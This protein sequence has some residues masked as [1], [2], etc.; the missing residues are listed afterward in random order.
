MAIDPVSAGFAI[1]R[2]LRPWYRLKLARNRRRARL[3]KPLLPMSEDD[4]QIFPN[5]T[6]TYTGS[7]GAILT[8]IVVTLL[9]TVGVGECTPAAVAAMPNCISATDLAAALIT[10]GFGVMAVVGRF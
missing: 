4:M 8:Q 3:G 9:H 7:G 6:M 1:W 2:A 5:G 10:V